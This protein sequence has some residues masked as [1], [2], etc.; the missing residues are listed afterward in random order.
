MS[1]PSPIKLLGI[2]GSLRSQSYNSGALTRSALSCLK[3]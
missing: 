2:S 3:A 1:A